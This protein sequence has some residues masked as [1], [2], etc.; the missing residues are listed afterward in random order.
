MNLAP[1]VGRNLGLKWGGNHMNK[2]SI[3]HKRTKCIDE[4]LFFAVCHAINNGMKKGMTEKH[5]RIIFRKVN[6]VH[7]LKH[8]YYKIFTI[9]S[10]KSA[11]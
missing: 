8:R 5:F 11:L 1:V 7:T 9:I 6:M 2:I 10:K 3:R 4:C